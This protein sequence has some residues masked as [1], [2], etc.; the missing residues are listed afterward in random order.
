MS[1]VAC[2]GLDGRACRAH[3]ETTCVLMKKPWRDQAAGA[4]EAR[5]ATDCRLEDTMCAE[6][7]ATR[8]A[9]SHWDS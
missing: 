8:R 7:E 5:W 4:G 2:I 1:Q 6:D 9:A 3:E